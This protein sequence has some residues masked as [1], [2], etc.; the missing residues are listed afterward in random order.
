MTISGVTNDEYYFSQISEID[1]KHFY[2]CYYLPI[3]TYPNQ[4]NPLCSNV[5]K[6]AIFIDEY[7]IYIIFLPFFSVNRNDNE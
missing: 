3:C 2:L 1:K 4:N 7:T 5:Y 6:I